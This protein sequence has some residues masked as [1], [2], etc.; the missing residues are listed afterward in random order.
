MANTI[1]FRRELCPAVGEIGF[2]SQLDVYLRDTDHSASSTLELAKITTANVGVVDGMLVADF[3]L[4]DSL[5]S[6]PEEII[7]S[8]LIAGGF[9]ES[10]SGQSTAL[11]L[12]AMIIMRRWPV[13]NP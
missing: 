1:H 2:E 12:N 5:F 4:N 8:S 11:Q 9:P 6:Q 3:H 7:V 13:P 10:G